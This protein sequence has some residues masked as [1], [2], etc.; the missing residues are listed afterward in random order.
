MPVLTDQSVRPVATM[1]DGAARLRLRPVPAVTGGGQHH[2]HT[3]KA[4]CS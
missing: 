3:P 2:S 4:R 1:L